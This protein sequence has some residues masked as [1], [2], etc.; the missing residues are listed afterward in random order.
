MC[1]RGWG[2]WQRS[3]IGWQERKRVNCERSGGDGED[4]VLMVE[5]GMILIRKSLNGVFC[6][7]I[8]EAIG[9]KAGGERGYKQ[10]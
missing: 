5:K 9:N 7:K 8:P 1:W 3:G 2:C 10:S 6:K 4:P